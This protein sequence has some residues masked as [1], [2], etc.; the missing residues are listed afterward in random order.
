MRKITTAIALAAAA[1][2]GQAFAQAQNFAGFQLGASIDAVSS[3]TELS[4]SGFSE[5]QNTANV[6]LTAQYNWALGNEWV[7]GVG[8]S[9]QLVD[10][11]AGEANGIE[12][13]GKN[14]YSVFV[15]PGL[16][17]DASNLVYAK[18][19]A[20]GTDGKIT[21]SGTEGSKTLSGYGIGFGWQTAL[22]K[23]I[24]LSTEFMAKRYDEVDLSASNK[25]K[26]SSNSLSLG[27]AYKF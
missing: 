4:S 20:V 1:F 17:L 16:A 15:A 2:T 13:K 12:A 3:K 22:T 26:G 18:V 24:L 8:A 19:A 25:V 11:K 6:S 5:S 23:N 21:Q 7:L 27:V 9:Y 10:N 14:T